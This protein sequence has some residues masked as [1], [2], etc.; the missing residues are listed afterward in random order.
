MGVEEWI[1]VF[2][3]IGATISSFLQRRERKIRRNTEAELKAEK[4]KPRVFSPLEVPFTQFFSSV[5]E[6]V[7]EIDDL[8]EKTDVDRVVFFWAKNGI[9]DPKF[10]TSSFQHR[11]GDSRKYEYVEYPLDDDYRARLAEVFRNGLVLY[12]VSNMPT[13]GCEIGDIYRMEGVTESFWG[14]IIKLHGPGGTAI[15]LYFSIATHTPGGFSDDSDTLIKMLHPKIKKLAET[16][17]I[18]KELT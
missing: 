15:Y 4:S 5:A 9:E 7:D 10:T 3:A 13:E 11:T 18:P 17:Y 16:Y 14:D 1:A 12:N 6:I 2:G 8:L